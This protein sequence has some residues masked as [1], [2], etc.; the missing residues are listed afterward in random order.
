MLFLHL[1]KQYL[2][3][4]S[5]ML[6]FR[7]SMFQLQ[8]FLLKT[9]IFTPIM[10]WIWIFF[11]ICTIADL[12]LMN[13]I[14]SPEL[15]RLEKGSCLLECQAE[16]YI[17]YRLIRLSNELKRVLLANYAGVDLDNEA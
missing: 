4:D 3:F 5:R 8:T 2:S 1:S 12:I 16:K 10:L 11:I 17:I 6:T 15:N 13:D 7:E 14:S 9:H